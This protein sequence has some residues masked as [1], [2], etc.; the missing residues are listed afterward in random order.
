RYYAQRWTI[1]CFFRQAQ[2]QLKLDGY[3][4]RHIRAVKRYWAVVLLSCV[5]SIAESR[6]NLSTGLEL[7]RSRKDHSVV[8]F[9][10]DA[11]KQEI[12]IDVIKK[13]LRIA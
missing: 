12:P 1:E 7:L 10:Y 6:Q 2:D 5:Y 8:E 9:I 3:R 13:Q 11:A 4:V